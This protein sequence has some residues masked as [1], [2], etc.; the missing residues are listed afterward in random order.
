MKREPDLLARAQLRDARR[1]R[2]RGLA[3]RDTRRQRGGVELDDGKV[4]HGVDVGDARA[5]G[6][7]AAY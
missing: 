7:L 5:D 6:R 1:R 3:D 2:E 4:V